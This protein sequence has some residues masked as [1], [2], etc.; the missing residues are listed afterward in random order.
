V[1]ASRADPLTTARRRLTPEPTPADGPDPYGSADPEWLRIDWRRQLRTID[2]PTP[3]DRYGPL[4]EPG[5]ATGR[6]PATRVNYVEMGS[7]PGLDVVLVH[8][9][10]GCWQNWL[11][12]I[13]QLARRR[14]VVAIDLPGFG[15]SPMPPW[16]ISVE[17]YGRIVVDAATELGLDDCA[18]VGNS[19]GG[20]I[21]AEAAIKAPGRFERT[22]L[23]SAAGASHARMRR[24][25]AEVAGRLAV[26]ASPLIL[27]LQE[28]A[29]SREQVR[30]WTFGMIFDQPHLLPPEL[31][32][33][34]FHNG[35][36][37]PGFLPA[38]G[39]LIGYDILDRLSDVDVPAL[40]VWGRNDR[41]VPVRDALEYGSRLTSSRTEI[42]A[43]TGHVPMAERPVRFNRLVEGFL[44]EG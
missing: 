1:W 18:I 24:E 10:S 39:A 35:A 37:K 7:G 12:N 31:L 30:R 27:K 4:L 19:L 9:L 43:R 44:D 14:R 8:G 20:F 22:A 13:P 40:V 23:V 2:V 26:A 21:A 3:G 32:W 41:I 11:E 42:F 5:G 33:E 36:G 28:R 29:I 15:S 38:L 25:P 17:R 16:P 34:F 6:P